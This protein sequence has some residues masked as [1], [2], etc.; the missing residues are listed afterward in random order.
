MSMIIYSR[1]SKHLAGA[2]SLKHRVPMVGNRFPDQRD[3]SKVEHQLSQLSVMGSNPVLN[4][5]SRS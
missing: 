4:C 1:G 3:S 2:A 5:L